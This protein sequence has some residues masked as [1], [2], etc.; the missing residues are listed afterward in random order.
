MPDT[1]PELELLADGLSWPTSLAFDDDGVP[2]VAESGLPFGGA[3]PGGR[4]LRLSRRGTEV[5][6]GGLP[7]PVNGLTC[8]QGAIFI[9]EGGS[10]GRI[11]RIDTDGTLSTILDDLPGGGNYHTNMTAIGPDG[12]LYFSQGAM[13]NTAIVGLDALELGW[14]R[15][16]PHAYDVPGYDVVLSGVNVATDNPLAADSSLAVTGA[17]VPFG[18]PTSRG[19]RVA[20]RVPCSASVMSCRTDGSDLRVVAWGLRNAFGLGFLPDGRLLAI[21][22]GAD[23][24]GSRPIGEAPDMLF[25][26]KE[27]AWYGWPDFIGGIP[28]TD[29]RFRP[30]RGPAPAFVLA[31]HNELPPPERAILAFPPHSAAVKFDVLPPGSPFAG[32]LLVALFGDERPMTAPEGPKTGRSIVRVDPSDWSLHRFTAGSFL[33]PIDVRVNPT[34]GDVHVLDFGWF[35]M[36]EGGSL[37]ARAWTGAL[38]RLAE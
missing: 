24:R 35:E 1:A 36:G 17:F 8:Y 30:Q 32:H 18:T 3:E 21:D 13:T 15:R 5:L 34:T 29:P 33:R 38:W 7:A 12:R 25:E 16:L 31:N 19:Q 28:V 10:P 27:S 26:V 11:S 14:L 9:S 23:D 37:A 4:V 20:A 22:Q 6:A 2:L